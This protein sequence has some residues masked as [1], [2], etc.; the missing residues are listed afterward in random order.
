MLRTNYKLLL[1]FCAVM[2][3]TVMSGCHPPE[4][5]VDELKVSAPSSSDEQSEQTKVIDLSQSVQK[6]LKLDFGE[7]RYRPLD[8]IVETNG[9]VLPNANTMTLVH[10][11]VNGRVLDVIVQVGQE[12]KSG[13]KLA[14]I[15]SNDIQQAEAELLQ[16]EAQING[17]LKRDLLQI[18]YELNQAETHLKL[19][20]SAFNRNKQLLDEGIAAPAQF[21]QARTEYESDQNTIK[22]LKAK[23]Q[24]TI[25]LAKQQLAVATGP[26]KQRLR[27]L[28]V[29]DSVIDRVLIIKRVNPFV[30][31]VSPRAGVVVERNVNPGE[32]IEPND[33][34]FAVGDFSTVWLKADIY[35][36]DVPDIHKGQRIELVAN[37]F[38]NKMFAGT[39]NFVAESVNQETRTL[40][41]RA[42]VPNPRHLLKP[43]MFGRMKILVTQDKVLSAPKEAVQDAGQAKVVYVHLEG[44]RFEERKI[45]IGKESDGF[46][47]VVSGV[48]DGEKV[49]TAGSFDLRAKALHQ[50]E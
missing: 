48:R 45:E 3:F 37:S 46:V 49:V 33:A 12:V 13:Q 10:T 27:L 15:S 36:K 26:I 24:A 42:E 23:R 28:G 1:F 17:G 16:S 14:S 5:K 6:A 47:E 43:K 21:E 7:V 2:N 11:T 50:V 32:L 44:D 34:L 35:E 19:S 31:I 29:T 8:L 4:E 18:D 40:L 41:V 39:L 25:D 38:P 22:G 20:Q 9:E 30:H